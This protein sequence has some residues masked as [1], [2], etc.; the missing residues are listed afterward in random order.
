[1]I[2]NL[3]DAEFETGSATDD[4]APVRI[5]LADDNKE[6]LKL[7]KSLVRLI[8]HEVVATATN[9]KDCIRL[10]EQLQPDVVIL[11][12]GMPGLDGIE[13]AA[14]ILEESDVPIIISTGAVGEYTFE[15]LGQVD[16]AGCLVKPFS[17][18]QLKAAIHI[19]MRSQFQFSL[20]LANV[21]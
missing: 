7:L 14:A 1:M 6:L 11:D 4:G 5:L 15:R 2:T 3:S 13:T 16:I 20:P 9:G 21:A 12:I 17:T 18:Q 19:A 10:T 8:G